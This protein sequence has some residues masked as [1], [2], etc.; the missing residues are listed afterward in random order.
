M[1]R[2]IGGALPSA[3]Y[4]G[5]GVI[6]ATATVFT[7]PTWPISTAASSRYLVICVLS[8]GSLQVSVT[9]NGVAATHL[10]SFGPDF[11]GIAQP[12][13]TTASIQVTMSANVANIVTIAT[14]A[15]YNLSS[16]TPYAVA[17]STANPAVLDL[18]VRNRGIILAESYSGVNG[19]S[20]TWTG[21]TADYV[22]TSSINNMPRSGAHVAALSAGTP[23][24]V[25]CAYSASSFP[26]AVALSWR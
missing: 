24:T 10:S 2:V 7:F 22:Q 3:V 5:T 16:T 26:R 20:F 14:W 4:T 25:R 18:N 12:A 23:A 1:M 15:L 9:V 13:G 21:V 6:S 19:A 17:T 11:W 8:Q